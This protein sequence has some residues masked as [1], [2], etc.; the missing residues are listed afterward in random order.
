[1]DKIKK[2][3]RQN[4]IRECRIGN[5]KNVK[6]MLF[7]VKQR[8]NYNDMEKKELNK[9]WILLRNYYKWLLIINI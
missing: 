4:V 1:M 3:N 7:S 9:Y 8:N 5:F 6:P 2:N